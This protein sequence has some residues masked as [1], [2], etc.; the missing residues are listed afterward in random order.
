MNLSR[1]NVILA[2]LLV[3]VTLAAGMTQVDYTRPNFEVLPDMK[4]TPAW[5]SFA[6]NPNFGNGRTLQSPVIGTIARGELP[7]HFLARPEDAIRAGQELTN[8]FQANTVEKLELQGDAESKPSEGVSANELEAESAAADE[9]GKSQARWQ[10]SVQRGSDVYR[11]FCV[12][13]HGPGGAGD[14]PVPKKGFPPPPSLVSGKSV[15]M[16]DGQL[17]HILTYGQ[18]S[19]PDFAGQLSRGTRW[20]VINYVRSLQSQGKI[21]TTSDVQIAPPQ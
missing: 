14:G 17:F 1:I 7:L 6:S 16:L 8:P 2:S 4:Y 10:D 9:A 11:V 15:Q 21:S 3:A 13:C 12:C 18:A 5:T 20:D 19:M